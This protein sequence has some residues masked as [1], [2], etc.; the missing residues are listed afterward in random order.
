MSDIDFDIDVMEPLEKNLILEKVID[1]SSA[2]IFNIK[3]DVFYLDNENMLSRKHKYSKCQVVVNNPV[4][5]KNDCG[6]IIGSSVV[7]VEGKIVTADIFIDYST[8]ERLDMETKNGNI[9][10]HLDG[11]ATDLTDDGWCKFVVSGII[12]GKHPNV[13]SRVRPA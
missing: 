9:Y 11:F 13:D 10:P 2:K 7:E 1:E 12:L 6:W 4:P 5:V 8:P 3:L